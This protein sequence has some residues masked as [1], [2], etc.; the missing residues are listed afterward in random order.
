MSGIGFGLLRPHDSKAH[1]FTPLCLLTRQVC[2]DKTVHL[3]TCW[4]IWDF[5]RIYCYWNRNQGQR[6]HTFGWNHFQ[7][8]QGSFSWISSLLE[9]NAGGVP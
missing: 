5:S 1:K 4:C 7:L 8:R 9:P 6:S 2:L 3:E